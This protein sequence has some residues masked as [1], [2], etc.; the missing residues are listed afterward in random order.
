MRILKAKVENTE[1]IFGSEVNWI[2][3]DLDN[4]MK[5]KQVKIMSFVLSNLVQSYVRV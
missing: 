1:A 5:E 2:A 3:L 4:I